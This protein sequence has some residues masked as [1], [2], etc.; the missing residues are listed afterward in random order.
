MLAGQLQFGSAA[1]KVRLSAVCGS[2]VAAL[3][4]TCWVYL[5][6]LTQ[7][8]STHS[9]N[10]SDNGRISPLAV[11]LSGLFCHAEESKPSH[12]GDGVPVLTGGR[13]GLIWQPFVAHVCADWRE[14]Q[15]C[16]GAGGA[17][18]TDSSSGA[19]QGGTLTEEHLPEPGFKIKDT[20]CGI[21]CWQD[22]Q[23]ISVMYLTL[24]YLYFNVY[25]HFIIVL[26]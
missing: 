23:W 5:S 9:V 21:H 17:G 12:L 3:S 15:R 10:L 14:P 4:L 22:R 26:F 1:G 25:F 13:R 2:C 16:G 18:R 20:L 7:V 24:K 19:G 6:Q 8:T 11:C